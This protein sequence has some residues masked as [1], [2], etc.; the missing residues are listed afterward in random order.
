[1][2]QDEVTSKEAELSDLAEELSGGLR[3]CAPAHRVPLARPESNVGLVGLH[4]PGKSKSDDELQEESLDGNDR[5]HAAERPGE[6]EALEGIHDLEEYQHHDNCKGVRD[7]SEDATE[8][9]AA[10]AE[11][12]THTTSHREE[13]RADTR[14]DSDRTECNDGDPN[15]RCRR[16]GR[17]VILFQNTTRVVD[18]GLSIDEEVR[19]QGDGNQQQRGDDFGDKYI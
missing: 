7:G 19:D 12:G 18:S 10:H 14:V 11:E 13:H 5:N 16:R 17:V 9:L 6:V 3:Q 4:L 8:L 1:M 2:A 15:E